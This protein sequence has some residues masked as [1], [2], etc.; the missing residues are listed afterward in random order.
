[1]RAER[2]RSPEVE[3]APAFSY[4]G[5]VVCPRLAAAALVLPLGLA[6]P[7]WAHH[8]HPGGA[9]SAALMLLFAFEGAV[10]SVHH[11]R[12]SRGQERCAVESASSNLNGVQ[13]GPIDLASCDVVR[14]I[15]FPARP[16][17]AVPEAP[18][19]E[20]PRAPPLLA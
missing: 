11:V 8:G 13:A 19:A 12:D 15:V 5:R 16:E 6:T 2:H 14:A 9:S 1:M 18:R 4:A 20:Q 7:S 17:A 3:A 10:H